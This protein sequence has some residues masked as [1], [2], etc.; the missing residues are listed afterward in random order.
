MIRK[1]HTRQKSVL[2]RHA[3]PDSKQQ[4]K[5]SCSAEAFWYLDR[6]FPCSGPENTIDY[7]T[8]NVRPGGS[9]KATA[10]DWRSNFLYSK[11]AVKK[12]IYVIKEM[13]RA[14]LLHVSA[15]SHGRRVQRRKVHRGLGRKLGRIKSPERC[16][17]LRRS[18]CRRPRGDAA[19]GP[20]AHLPI[21][22]ARLGIELRYGLARLGIEPVSCDDVEGLARLGIE[23]VSVATGR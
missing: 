7:T 1:C 17:R 8:K 16:A 19:W 20:A 14:F 2:Q 23:P 6:G 21:L 9:S 3:S 5:K 12:Y 18:A 10:V 11:K 22:D 15:L 13:E 4:R